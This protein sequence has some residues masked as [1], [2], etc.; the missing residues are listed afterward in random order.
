MSISTE[1]LTAIDSLFEQSELIHMAE[2]HF[3]EHT[4]SAG[5]NELKQGIIAIIKSEDKPPRYIDVVRH[6]QSKENNSGQL[7]V[8]LHNTIEYDQIIVDVYL[9]TCG[10]ICTNVHNMYKLDII[11]IKS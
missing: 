3:D 4:A 10:R 8:Q 2:N 11:S 6:L 9:D 7:L 5:I 1:Q